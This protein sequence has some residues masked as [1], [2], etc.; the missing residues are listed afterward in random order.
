MFEF[1]LRLFEYCQKE[2]AAIKQ[3]LLPLV[4]VGALISITSIYATEEVLTHEMNLKNAA[5]QSQEA[6]NQGLRD[7]ISNYEAASKQTPAEIAERDRQIDELKT[8]LMM[9]KQPKIDPDPGG[10][11]RH[12]SLEQLWAILIELHKVATSVPR[13]TVAC[14][15]NPEAVQYAREFLVAFESAGLTLD[16]VKH[17]EMADPVMV[18]G[19]SPDEHGIFVAVRDPAHPSQSA[20]ILVGKLRQAHLE[21]RFTKAYYQGSDQEFDQELAFVV[22]P[23]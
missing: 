17:H 2:W 21:V 16:N 1:L 9:A 8:E 11:V 15:D 13:F 20:L 23:R 22:G 10:Q 4:V 14:V 12:L 7:R 5:I 3:A 19:D 18:H 6:I